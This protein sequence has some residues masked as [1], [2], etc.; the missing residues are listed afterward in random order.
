MPNI[1]NL[2]KEVFPNRLKIDGKIHNISSRKY[3]LKCSPFKTHNT[4]QIHLPPNVVPDIRCCPKCKKEKHISM[5]YD[6]KSKIGGSSYCKECVHIN[7]VERGRFRKQQYIS[8]KGNRCQICGYNKYYGAL[9]FHHL[10]PTQKEFE[11]S[12][13]RF[14]SFDKVKSELDKCILV[15]SNCHKEIHGNVASIPMMENDSAKV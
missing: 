12:S 14:K 9:E 13:L 7:T 11:I 6:R 5:F 3:C 10:D 2:C 15:C 1:C 4:R 8:Y